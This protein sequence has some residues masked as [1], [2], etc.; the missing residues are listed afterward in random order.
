MV[1]ML[2]KQINQ[3]PSMVIYIRNKDHSGINGVGYQHEL[4]IEH[5]PGHKHISLTCPGDVNI[6]KGVLY[7]L[8]GSLGRM[9]SVCSRRKKRIRI[10]HNVYQPFFAVNNG[11]IDPTTVES[12][13]LT[14]FLEKYSL[15]PSFSFAEGLGKSEQNLWFMEWCYWTGMLTHLYIPH[16]LCVCKIKQKKINYFCIAPFHNSVTGKLTILG[17]QALWG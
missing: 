13:F 8:P 17:V 1:D 10:A 2:G 9:E 5:N 14:T 15:Q 16:F 7:D 3:R 12:I 6:R 11:L 4:W